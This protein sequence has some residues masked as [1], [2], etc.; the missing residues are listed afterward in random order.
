MAFVVGDPGFLGELE[1]RASLGSVSESVGHSPTSD[2]V[3]DCSHVEGACTRRPDRRPSDCVA[4]FP[5]RDTS[6]CSVAISSAG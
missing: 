1:R 5:H 6:E 3:P 2:L 4:S